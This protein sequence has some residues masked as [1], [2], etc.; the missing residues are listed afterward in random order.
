MTRAARCEI[1]A[2]WPRA[3]RP[4]RLQRGMQSVSVSRLYHFQPP[5]AD[6]MSDT[7][8]QNQH[9]LSHA[10]IT[11]KVR[12]HPEDHPAMSSM[13]PNLQ[14][15]HKDEQGNEEITSHCKRVKGLS[16]I[17]EFLI[18][19]AKHIP[20]AAAEPGKATAGANLNADS[21]LRRLFDRL[22]HPDPYQRF[23]AYACTCSYSPR[24]CTLG[25]LRFWQGHPGGHFLRNARRHLCGSV[26][27]MPYSL[28]L[29]GH[30]VLESSS[31]HVPPPAD[32]F[33]TLSGVTWQ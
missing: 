12:D 30:A 23:V 4:S 15:C 18:W 31:I 8:C 16:P 25:C 20:A 19:S 7:D 6:W 2:L 32:V 11:E 1:C 29:S 14:P 17:A 22:A 33:S 10:R 26:P 5:R 28:N 27:Q 24:V 13:S 9:L 21:L 3:V